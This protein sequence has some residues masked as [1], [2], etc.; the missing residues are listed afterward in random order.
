MSTDQLAELS[1]ILERYGTGLVPGVIAAKKLANPD[2]RQVSPIFTFEPIP[3]NKCDDLIEFDEHVNKTLSKVLWQDWYEILNNY[4]P[5]ETEEMVVLAQK[6][7]KGLNAKS[8]LEKNDESNLTKHELEDFVLQGQV[9]EERMT[10]HNLRLVRQSVLRLRQKYPGLDIEDLFQNGIMGLMTAI[11]KWDW[12]RG[13]NFSTYAINWINQSISREILN[14]S[15]IVRLPVHRFN[16]IY[17]DWREKRWIHSDSQEAVDISPTA[18]LWPLSPMFGLEV[19]RESGDYDYLA[20]TEDVLEPIL[21]DMTYKSVL[22]V[23]FFPLDLKSEQILKERFG[24]DNDPKTLD[25]IGKA[26]SLSRERIRQIEMIAF[27]D[28]RM[29]ALA[30]YAYDVDLENALRDSLSES[31]FKVIKK[32]QLYP[33]S[34]TLKRSARAEGIPAVELDDLLVKAIRVLFPAI[35]PWQ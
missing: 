20:K 23:L 32:I 2:I 26:F 35:N 15:G 14:T 9:A 28:M 21:L 8:S 13:Y 6:R 12:Q 11:R 29:F 19:L 22:N 25:E 24:F 30:S 31:E 34:N 18:S 4:P 27:N 17:W 7:E 1:E 10:T 33:D 5:L 16:N 3:R